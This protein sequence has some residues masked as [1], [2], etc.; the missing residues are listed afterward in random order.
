MQRRTSVDQIEVTRIGALQVR[1]AL[2]IEDNGAVIST[3]WHRTVCVPGC[4]IDEQMAAVNTHLAAMGENIVSLAD[5]ER[6]KAIA[7]AAWAPEVIA[8]W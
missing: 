4:D 2:E 5:I 1:I 6:I 8:A 3:K 7:D